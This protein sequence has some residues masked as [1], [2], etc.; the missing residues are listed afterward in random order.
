MNI[1]SETRHAVD[2]D[3]ATFLSDISQTDKR[4]TSQKEKQAEIFE[5]NKENKSAN[6]SI[7]QF[8]RKKMAE[9][10][11]L[12]GN[13]Y[14]KSKESQEAIKCYS[15]SLELFSDDPATYSNRALAYLKT[16]EYA[17]ALE[18]AEAAIKLKEDYIKAYHRRGKAYAALNKLE[19][20]IRDF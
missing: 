19:L 11:R 15:K 17:R 7:E 10:E 13:E 14:M 20:A 3:I 18:D 4:L 5:G 16:K 1:T 2:Q 12:K 9:N 8:E 6:A